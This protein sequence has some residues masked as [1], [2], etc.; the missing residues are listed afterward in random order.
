[1]VHS[2]VL[3]NLFIALFLN[4]AYASISI[5]TRDILTRSL[6]TR[7]LSFNPDNIPAECSSKCKST[8]AVLSN[9]TCITPSCLCTSSVNTGFQTCM[10]CLLASKGNVPA[11]IQQD[12]QAIS[13][14]SSYH[15]TG[16]IK[17]MTIHS[18]RGFMWKCRN[19]LN[20]SYCRRSSKYISHRGD[21]SIYF[22]FAIRDQ[23]TC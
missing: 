14:K 5:A 22:C 19:I 16:Y 17:L 1:M 15:K 7:Q 12:Q 6:E 23:F 18:I 10:N 20:V 11:D 2:F 13:C 4:H 3:L 9:S 8:V 21:F